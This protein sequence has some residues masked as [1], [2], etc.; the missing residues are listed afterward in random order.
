MSYYPDSR[1]R[2]ARKRTPRVLIRLGL[3]GAI[4]S[5]SLAVAVP[6]SGQTP[7]GLYVRNGVL[8][9][10]G[11][12]Y[13][14]I[15]AN[16]QT[17]FA[18]LMNNQNDTSS[19]ENLAA[20]GKAGIPFVRF[21]ASGFYP[22]NQKLYLEDRPEFF[23]RMDRV[24]KSAEQ[25][26]VGL[27]PSLFWRLRTVAELVGEQPNQFGSPESKSSAFIRQFTR[28]MVGRYKNSP[29]IWGWEFGNEANL[30]TDIPPMQPRR[31]QL[32]VRFGGLETEGL[33]RPV[34]T[35][36]SLRAVHSLFAKTV[37]EIDSS[38]I[39]ETG[40]GL[41]RPAAWHNARGEFRQ[42]DNESQFTSV[43]LSQNPAPVDVISVHIYEKPLRAFHFGSGRVAP[44]I[45]GLMQTSAA[46]RK[47]LFIGEFPT[48]N[49]AQTDEFLSAIE[50][51]HVPL[52]AF[53]V[54]DYPPQAATMNVDFHNE[55]AFVIDQVAKA[56][57]V[58]QAGSH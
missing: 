55:R 26:H 54:F 24:V 19:L 38:R 27:I 23:R 11:Q 15:G 8:M 46:A 43:L 4:L 44:F 34:F 36:E 42:P 39:I 29:A 45:A 37:R 35:S 31:R 50:E 6:A 2:A 14:G 17:L 12:P 9:R 40:C 1:L 57:A 21:R 51:N 25:N 20:L 13:H 47:P 53:W 56:N 41:P 30:A 28:E 48:R 33:D 49:R 10:H 3:C 7:E 32:G 22:Q 58:L 5:L 52:S 16:Y 18:R